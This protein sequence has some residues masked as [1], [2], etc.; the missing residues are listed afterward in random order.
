ARF[1]LV[2]GEQSCVFF[3]L[4]LGEHSWLFL[5]LALGEDLP[6]FVHLGRCFAA[7]GFHPS[8]PHRT[9]CSLVLSQ[10]SQRELRP[11]RTSSGLSAAVDSRSAAGG[12]PRGRRVNPGRGGSAS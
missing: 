7:E 2:P 10:R 12:L 1:H 6:Y 8:T 3:D 11:L 5:D 4:E 9:R